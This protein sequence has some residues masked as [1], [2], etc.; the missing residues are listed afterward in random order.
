[1]AAEGANRTVAS[2]AHTLPV[3]HTVADHVHR[4]AVGI[5]W[6][7]SVLICRS[8]VSLQVPVAIEMDANLIIMIELYFFWSFERK[9][10]SI[11]LCLASL[12]LTTDKG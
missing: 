3:F 8:D 1:V 12:I 9:K 4:A 5:G 10:T 2:V 6:E 7:T 11:T